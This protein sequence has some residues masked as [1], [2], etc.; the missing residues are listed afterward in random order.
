MF[1]KDSIFYQIND[2]IIDIMAILG[3]Q[4]FEKWL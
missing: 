3:R 1:H 4:D 2:D